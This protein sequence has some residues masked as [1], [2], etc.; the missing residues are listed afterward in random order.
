MRLD[1]NQSE[2]K[3]GD[4]KADQCRVFVMLEAYH[5]APGERRPGDGADHQRDEREAG[6]AGGEPIHAFKQDRCV[7]G[8]TDEHANA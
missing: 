1:R 8:E 5:H 7:D 6:L 2:A 4:G 3:C